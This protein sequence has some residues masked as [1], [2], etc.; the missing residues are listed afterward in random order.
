MKKIRANYD[1]KDR[2]ICVTTEGQHSFYYQPTK[3]KVRYWLFSTKDFSGSIFAYFR[4]YGRCMDGNGFSLTI[5]EIY[6]FKSYGKNGKSKLGR[7]F[8]RIPGQIEYVLHES[9]AK[10][11]K[12]KSLMDVTDIVPNY[13]YEIDSEYAA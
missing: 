12:Y 3:E 4:K 9:V 10:E 6:E 7:V 5:K 1:S 11:E 13:H 8:G 2:V